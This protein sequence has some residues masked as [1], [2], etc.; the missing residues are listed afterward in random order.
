MLEGKEKENST[1]ADIWAMGC[2]FYYMLFGRLPFV[3]KTVAETKALIV[4]GEIKIPEDIMVPK[5]VQRLFS[6]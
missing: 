4:A 3:G 1:A 6:K 2:I 5:N